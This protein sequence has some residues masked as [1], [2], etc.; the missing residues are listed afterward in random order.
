MAFQLP[1]MALRQWRPPATP[2]GISL[3][4]VPQQQTIGSPLNAENLKRWLAQGLEARTP[5]PVAAPVA[6]PAPL[7]KKRLLREM[8]GYGERAGEG[9]SMG[10]R[11]G[12]Y[13]GVS[14]GGK[15]LW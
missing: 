14:S 9:G 10:G 4:Y 12:G 13:G 8:K 5:P 7:A 6:A 15:G 1:P 3:N 11:G 2:P